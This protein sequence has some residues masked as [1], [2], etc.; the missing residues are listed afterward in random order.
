[1]TWKDKHW[2]YYSGAKER[3][4]QY[5]STRPGAI[6][7]ATLALDRFVARHAESNGTITTRPFEFVGN[8]LQFNAITKPEGG[9]WLEF[10][11]EDGQVINGFKTSDT[12]VGDEFRQLVTFDGNADLSALRGK[13]VAFRF[14][15][16]KAKLYSFGVLKSKKKLSQVE[17]K[18]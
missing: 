13:T 14:H 4:G 10:L 5:K 9:V 11:D 1:M 12:F 16:N 17:V 7:L 8:S 18:Q 15:L 6:G 2:L 3:H